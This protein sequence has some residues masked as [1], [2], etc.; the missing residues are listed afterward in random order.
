MALIEE[1]REGLLVTLSTEMVINALNSCDFEGQLA[2]HL[3]HMEMHSS[4]FDFPLIV[5]DATVDSVHF[6]VEAIKVVTTSEILGIVFFSASV[7]VDWNEFDFI[8]GCEEE[9]RGTAEIHITPDGRVRHVHIASVDP[10]LPFGDT[11]F[12]LGPS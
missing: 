8:S 11:D 2:S 5:E 4:S 9:I 10:W 12:L 7:I 1:R 6:Q 3:I